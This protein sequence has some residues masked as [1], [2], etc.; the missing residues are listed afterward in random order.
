MKKTILAC[1]IVLLSCA[2]AVCQQQLNAATKED[3][4]ELL[5][6]MGSRE[7][8]Q[9]M[10]A[11]MGQQIA[12]TAADSYRLKHPDSTPLQLRQVAEL[13]G[14]SFQS[15]L[16]VINIDEMLDAIIPVYQQHL[17]HADVRAII[18]FYHS[19][20]GQKFLRELPGLTAESMQAMQPILNKHLPEMQAAADKAIA[21][22][23]KKNGGPDRDGTTG[24]DDGK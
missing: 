22:T 23:L 3:V 13:A 18:D 10:W 19:E 8:I 20:V 4:Q 21:D 16:S 5:V 14:K 17:T 7:R 24:S 2:P 9:Q 1:L 15:S 6:L 12:S 11:Q